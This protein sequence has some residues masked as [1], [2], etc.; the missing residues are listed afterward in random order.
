MKNCVVLV[1]GDV[2]RAANDP[3]LS[4]LGPAQ[5]AVPDKGKAKNAKK[6]SGKELRDRRSR[7]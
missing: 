6:Q 7:R 5:P 2:K 1:L 4:L 3:I